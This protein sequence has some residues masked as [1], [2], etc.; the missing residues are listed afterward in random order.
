MQILSIDPGITTGIA[1]SSDTYLEISMTVRH[2]KVLSNGFL[3]KLVSMAKPDVV[4]IEDIPAFMPHPDMVKLKTELVR[5]FRVAG[6][7]V[8]EIKPSQWKKLTTRVE[9]PG[10]HARDAAT[11]SKWWVESNA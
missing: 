9:I 10:V 1:I 11:M 7:D 2:E 5:W 4:L 3:N 8:R 6:F